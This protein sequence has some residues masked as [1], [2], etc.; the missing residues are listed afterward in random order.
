MTHEVFKLSE[1]SAIL[2]LTESNLDFLQS[3]PK[4][5]VKKLRFKAVVNL[6]S[7]RYNFCLAKGIDQSIRCQI[8]CKFSSGNPVTFICDGTRRRNVI[9]VQYSVTILDQNNR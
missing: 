1:I 3:L 6:M 7:F 9:K 8:S 4:A 2:F 5:L